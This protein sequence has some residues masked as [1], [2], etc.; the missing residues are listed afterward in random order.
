MRVKSEHFDLEN[1]GLWILYSII[2][3]QILKGH[4]TFLVLTI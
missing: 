2:L 1:S 3:Q 4:V